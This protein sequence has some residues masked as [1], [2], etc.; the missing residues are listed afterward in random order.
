MHRIPRYDRI[1]G[2]HLTRSKNKNGTTY[3]EWYITVQ[4]VNAGSRL[5]LGVLP[6]PALESVPK[7]VRGMIDR[8]KGEGTKIKLAF[9]TAGFSPPM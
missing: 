2:P 5:V 1:R 4:C 7:M 9:L 8:C 3:F 6:V